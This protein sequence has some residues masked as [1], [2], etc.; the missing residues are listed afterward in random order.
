[1]VPNRYKA[2]KI[3]GKWVSHLR[4]YYANNQLSDERVAALEAVGFV[5]NPHERRWLDSYH[6]LV[7]YKQKYVPYFGVFVRVCHDVLV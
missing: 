6:R 4:E 3:L 2:D 7:E 1:M 5:W